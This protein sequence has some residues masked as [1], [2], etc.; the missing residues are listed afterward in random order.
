MAQSGA[1]MYRSIGMK[2]DAMSA[3]SIMIDKQTF[4]GSNTM[5]TSQSMIES[6][7]QALQY[8]PQSTTKPSTWLDVLIAVSVGLMLAFGALSY[9]D[10]LTK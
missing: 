4:K 2:W 6:Y 10:V 5:K 7:N 3:L 1:I 9:F 8:G